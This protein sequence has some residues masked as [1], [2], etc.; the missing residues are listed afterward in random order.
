MSEKCGNNLYGL[1]DAPAA[2]FLLG[3]IAVL[4]FSPAILKR[5]SKDTQVRDRTRRQDGKPI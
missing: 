1:A 2:G 3:G 4:N 5:G